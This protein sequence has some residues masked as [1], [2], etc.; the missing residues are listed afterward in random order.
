MLLF[1]AIAAV[2]LPST[3]GA[4]E[5]QM[6][7]VSQSA[8]KLAAAPQRLVES[9]GVAPVFIMHAADEAMVQPITTW[10]VA[11]NL[12]VRNGI[13]RPLPKVRLVALPRM[14]PGSK[15]EYFGGGVL[16]RSPEDDAVVWGLALEV[17]GAY[18]MRIRLGDVRLSGGHPDLGLRRK[19]RNR[20]TVRHRVGECGWDAVDAVRRRPGN[21]SRDFRAGLS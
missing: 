20:G 19:R 9:S 2:T 13:E 7:L 3:L 14:E 17:D 4:E 6:E 1:V 18:R 15:L 16:A 8:P 10:N 12:P 11:G 21:P 5:N